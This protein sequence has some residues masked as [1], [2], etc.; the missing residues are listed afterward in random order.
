MS[1]PEHQAIPRELEFP[2]WLDE[3]FGGHVVLKREHGQWYALLL[4]FDITGCGSTRAAAVQ[5]SF[6]LLGTYL[7]DYFEEGASFAD[8]IRPVPR[9]LR[10][11]LAVESI[12]GRPL[13][14]LAPRLALANESTYALPPGLLRFAH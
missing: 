14:S 12:L 10:A 3:D 2:A 4:E 6:A 11:R 9:R 5:D 13:R 8:A 7:H 1:A